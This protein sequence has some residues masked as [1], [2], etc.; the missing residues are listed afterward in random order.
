[1]FFGGFVSRQGMAEES[2]S[3]FEN[4]DNMNLKTENN[5]KRLKKKNQ[6]NRICKNCG[7]PKKDIK[8]MQYQ[9]RKKQGKEQ[10]QY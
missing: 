9:K 6:P 1:M 8:Y 3:K 4:Y 10:K 5:N 2:I 7:T